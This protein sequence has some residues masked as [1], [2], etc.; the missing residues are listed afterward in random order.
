MIIKKGSMMFKLSK[1]ETT[2]ETWEGDD[3]LT[4]TQHHLKFIG[5][6]PTVWD[7]ARNTMHGGCGCFRCKE[8]QPGLQ[9][10]WDMLGEV[11]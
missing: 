11:L 2:W 9:K 6:F 7:I 5:F 10:F 1:G 3:D 4:L 8:R